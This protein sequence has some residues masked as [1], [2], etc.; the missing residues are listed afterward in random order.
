MNKSHDNAVI[1]MMMMMVVITGARDLQKMGSW[2]VQR[3]SFCT[4]TGWMGWW[5]RN[6]EVGVNAL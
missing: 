1:M 6:G 3:E 5:I 4:V 2:I